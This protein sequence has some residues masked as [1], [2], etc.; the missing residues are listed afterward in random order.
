MMD[1]KGEMAVIMS[2][3]VNTLELYMNSSSLDG[4]TNLHV[5]QVTAE[6]FS[7]KLSRPRQIESRASKTIFLFVEKSILH[8]RLAS[9]PL[10]HFGCRKIFPDHSP[11]GFNV[12]EMQMKFDYA[13]H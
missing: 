13:F 9:L 8:G 2:L 5:G 3:Q 7:A 11:K 12:S 1:P 10:P 6:I 4:F